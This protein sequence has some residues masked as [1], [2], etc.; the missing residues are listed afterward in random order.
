MAL[1]IDVERAAQQ[2]RDALHILDRAARGQG[3]AQLF[4]ETAQLAKDREA[5]FEERIAVF[6]SL[7]NDL[8]EL[9]SGVRQ[10]LLRNAALS[11]EIES[12]AHVVDS[13]WVMRAIAG[14]DELHSGARR[15][16]NRQLGLDALAASLAGSSART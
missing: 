9:T 14:F 16:L 6:Y 7:L 2:R 11:K 10:P 1:A 15:N 12:L 3:F 4:V 5:P 13:T 8:L